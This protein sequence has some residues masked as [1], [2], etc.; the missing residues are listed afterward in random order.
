MPQF[1]ERALYAFWA[2]QKS[3]NDLISLLLK[4]RL[5]IRTLENADKKILIKEAKVNERRAL[6][7]KFVPF[8]SG[9]RRKPA[10]SKK[11]YQNAQKALDGRS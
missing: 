10:V 11:T 1:N 7:N 3:V 8:L 4:C 6:G 9:L 5:F 2:L